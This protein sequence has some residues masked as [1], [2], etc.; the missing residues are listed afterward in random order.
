M[1]TLGI[2]FTEH[3]LNEMALVGSIGNLEIIVYTCD[4]GFV[5]HVHVID[6]A[7]RG[8][9]FS[10]CIKLETPEYFP[11][12][13]KYTDKFNSKERKTFQKFME[14]A[15]RNK[16]YSTNYEYACSMWNDNNS[17][18]AVDETHSI[19]NYLELE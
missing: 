3:M 13:G 7:T 5:P 17:S 14:S 8:N 19:P 15:P 9:L 1:K 11:H 16:R 6:T 2:I 4:P 12:G 10:A 18:T